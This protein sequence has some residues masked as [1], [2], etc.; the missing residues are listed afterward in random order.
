MNK[1]IHLEDIPKNIS[2]SEQYWAQTRYSNNE[3]HNDLFFYATS[4]F[5]CL[6]SSMQMFPSKYLN[7][8]S[9]LCGHSSVVFSILER[10]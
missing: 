4:Q 7:W 3:S 6:F 10:R 1:N 9:G 5:Q 2:K 8:L